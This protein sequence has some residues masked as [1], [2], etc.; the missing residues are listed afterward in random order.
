LDERLQGAVAS[1][2]EREAV[3]V[4]AQTDA[5]ER[6]DVLAR[7]VMALEALPD[8][9]AALETEVE[10]LRK[11]DSL[12]EQYVSERLRRLEEKFEESNRSQGAALSRIE[13]FVQALTMRTQ[14]LEKRLSAVDVRVAAQNDRIDEV[15]GN[16]REES[17]TIRDECLPKIAV[18]MQSAQDRA[19]IE[20]G[21]DFVR[22]RNE[23]GMTEG[24]MMAALCKQA[25]LAHAQMSQLQEVV[26]ERVAC[27]ASPDPTP[28][29]HIAAACGGAVR[30]LPEAGDQL[31]PQ[32]ASL[33]EKSRL[34]QVSR[35]VDVISAALQRTEQDCRRHLGDFHVTLESLQRAIRDI[36][37]KCLALVKAETGDVLSS[38]EVLETRLQ[39]IEMER[40]QGPIQPAD[41]GL[42]QDGR[43]SERFD[44]AAV[45]G[46]MGA[47]ALLQVIGTV[48]QHERAIRALQRQQ[49]S[50]LTSLRDE[51]AGPAPSPIITRAQKRILSSPT[52][53]VGSKEGALAAVKVIDGMAVQA[54]RETKLRHT[55]REVS[56]CLLPGLQTR[57]RL[58]HDAS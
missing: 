26:L 47:D 39:T 43:V 41:D 23:M 44:Q 35:R 5:N 46:V 36:A 1:V 42:S 3:A 48:A 21:K 15:M 8:R 20:V 49:E 52:K 30:H 24:R 10:R 58:T 25:A 11:S 32:P 19:R 31:V 51:P 45:P 16:L 57:R 55:I 17:S 12:L 40:G 6:V 2:N 9:L 28:L 37:G 27:G 7:R 50:G 33:D 34:S 29:P 56:Q 38:L 13:G 54:A 53:H 14:E 22:I 18:D 4:K